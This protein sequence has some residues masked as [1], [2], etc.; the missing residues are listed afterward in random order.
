MASAHRFRPMGHVPLGISQAGGHWFESSTAHQKADKIKEAGSL[1]KRFRFFIYLH[2]DETGRL[3]LVVE[4]VF[5]ISS[6]ACTVSL[7]ICSG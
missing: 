3:Q 2:S 1:K 6:I 5:I 4:E 7:N